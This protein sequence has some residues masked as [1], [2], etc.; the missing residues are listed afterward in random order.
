[1]N[2]IGYDLTSW[3]S[4]ITRIPDDVLYCVF[5][6][7]AL[8]NNSPTTSKKTLTDGTSWLAVTCVCRQWRDLALA[9]PPLWT[10]LEISEESSAAMIR[11]YIQRSRHASLYVSFKGPI[12][13]S[14][15]AEKLGKIA[16]ALSRHSH[17]LEVFETRDLTPDAMEAILSPFVFPVPQLRT[18]ALSSGSLGPLAIVERPVFA[19]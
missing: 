13:R 11:A 4:P 1:M 17:R 10:R 6:L 14:E 18:L 12:L 15:T 2:G 16:Q 19:D 7:L 5:L 9:S 3:T 8:G